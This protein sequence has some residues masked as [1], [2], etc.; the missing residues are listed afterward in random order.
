MAGADQKAEK[1]ESSDVENETGVLPRFQQQMY[2][3][4]I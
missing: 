2:R 4:D 3:K 1:V